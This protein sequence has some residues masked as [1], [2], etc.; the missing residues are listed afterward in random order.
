MFFLCFLKIAPHL[1]VLY[2]GRSF[3]E[4]PL[5]VCTNLCLCVQYIVYHFSNLVFVVTLIHLCVQCITNHIYSIGLC[6]FNF[7]QLKTLQKC[8]TYHNMQCSHQDHWM[9]SADTLI[10]A[11]IHYNNINYCWLHSPVCSLEIVLHYELLY[12]S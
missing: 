10:M 6:V 2:T 12:V 9:M 8:L 5:N 7:P 4:L 3:R 1:I 11:F